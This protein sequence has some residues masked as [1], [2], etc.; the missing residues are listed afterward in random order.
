LHEVQVRLHIAFRGHD[1]GSV[2]MRSQTENESIL[3][4]VNYILQLFGPGGVP[5]DLK[6]LEIVVGWVHMAHQHEVRC[7][8]SKRRFQPVQHHLR[9]LNIFFVFK[10]RKHAVKRDYCQISVL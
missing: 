7:C 5:E 9:L 2:H 6:L 1:Q 4:G 3:V 10:E 8:V